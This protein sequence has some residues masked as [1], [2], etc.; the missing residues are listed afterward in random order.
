MFEMAGC[1]IS[2]ASQ[3]FVTAECLASVAV[4][5]LST[6][7]L[8]SG[9]IA[10]GVLFTLIVSRSLA[11]SV[12]LLIAAILVLAPFRQAILDQDHLFIGMALAALL[13]LWIGVF[14]YRRLIARQ[15]RALADLA[16]GNAE[17]EE[18]LDR[19]ITWRRAAEPEGADITNH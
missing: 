12:S 6:Y 11:I 13:L 19:E 14:G 10:A 9:A 7:P 4:Q 1:S 5:A 15:R 17:L 16:A 8:T 2:E 3:L 18:K